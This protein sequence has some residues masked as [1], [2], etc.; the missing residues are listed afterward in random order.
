MNKKYRLLLYLISAILL[1]GST[2]CLA[3]EQ[4]TLKVDI[5]PFASP[6]TLPRIGELIAEFEKANNIKVD[7]TVS[8]N[9]DPYR[10]KLLQDI[11][12]G[13]MADVA[14]VDGSW[15]PEFEA[16]GALVPLTKWFVPEIQDKFLDFAIDG[17]TFDGEL[18]AIW[19]HTG[20]SGLYYR[21]DLLSEAG[22]T[23]PP[24]TW[25]ELMEVAKKLTVDT[26]GDGIID[27]YGFSY[28]GM[29]HVVTTFT[30]YPFFWGNIGAEMT[31]DGKVSFGEGSDKEAMI[32]TVNF[33]EDL[34]KD[35]AATPD[36]PALS[37]IEIESNFIG[38]QC[39]MAVLGGWQHASIRQNAGDAFADNTGIA[40]I[41]YP[42][43]NGAP[44]ACAGGWAM[45]MFTKDESKQDAA[46]KF[47]EFWTSNVELQTVL[48]M[49]GQMSTLKEVYEQDE[50][51]A[52]NV[53]M[54]F[55]EI[56]KHGKTR[57]AVPYQGIMDLEFQEILQGAA[58]LESD[59][60]AMVDYAAETTI[61]KA[62]EAKVYPQD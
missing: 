42:D 39:A 44:V 22:Y 12:A 1:L 28:P 53:I 38:D 61:A 62:I 46:W 9:D 2:P 7:L 15:L 18:K 30:M 4:V 37:F 34:I 56:L 60:E 36:A 26:N 3:N 33:L 23:Q 24:A 45:G 47:L 49:S 10:I 16:I 5:Q 20:S 8:V 54:S 6:Q 55:Y 40:P 35:G 41:P 31:R 19:F 52:D 58:A 59:V 17:A 43:E 14:F 27:R 57:D 11:A 51:K 21:K 32:K 25:N 48:T 29:K 50:V 13:N